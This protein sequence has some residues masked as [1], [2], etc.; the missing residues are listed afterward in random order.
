MGY[1]S[2]VLIEFKGINRWWSYEASDLGIVRDAWALDEY[3]LYSGAGFLD[4]FDILYSELKYLFRLTCWIVIE[5]HYWI[6]FA[7]ALHN[8][9]SDL[10][11]IMLL[12]WFACWYGWYW[13]RS[14]WSDYRIGSHR[15]L[16]IIMIWLVGLGH[17]WF[18]APVWLVLMNLL[19]LHAD[20]DPS[21]LKL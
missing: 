14:I 5:L 1:Q 21:I 20:L 2:N 15:N 17:C 7:Y 12:N 4:L 18:G 8:P 3:A 16:D 6:G 9:K 11:R 10:T 19:S 13:C